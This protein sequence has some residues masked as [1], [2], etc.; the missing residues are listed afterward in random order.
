MCEERKRICQME[1]M[2]LHHTPLKDELRY[3]LSAEE[4]LPAGDIIRPE[5]AKDVVSL[6]SDTRRAAGVERESLSFMR[7][8]CCRVTA[9]RFTRVS[10]H[11]VG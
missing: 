9:Q 11:H 6:G 1:I 5:S 3:H 10:L 8:F 4:W 7:S 2:K